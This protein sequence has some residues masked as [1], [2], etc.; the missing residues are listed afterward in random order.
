M[1]FFYLYASQ[2]RLKDTYFVR[3]FKGERMIKKVRGGYVIVH[4]SK[5]RT[6]RI[7]ATPHPVSKAKATSIHRAIQA[8]KR[9]RG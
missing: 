8:S 2:V 1:G 5:G 7:K 9:K 3:L 6:G 4:C